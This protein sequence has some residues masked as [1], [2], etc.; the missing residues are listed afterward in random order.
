MQPSITFWRAW[1]LVVGTMVGSGVFLLPSVLGRFGWHG[2]WGWG[3]TATGAVVVALTIAWL[4]RRSPG[5]GG[6]YAYTKQAFGKLPAFFIAWGYWMSLWIGNAAI[7]VAFSGYAANLHPLL[8]NNEFYIAFGVV[9]VFTVVNWLGIA[10][11]G[12]VGLLFTVAKVVPLVL[13]GV[14][15]I[16]LGS[17]DTVA[18]VDITREGGSWIAA[19]A[20]MAMLALWAFTGLEAVTIPS[21]DVENPKQTL[22]KALITGVA[23]AAALY[24]VATFGVMMVVSTEQLATSGAPFA[25]AAQAL[26]GDVGGLLVGIGALIAIAGTLNALVMMSGQMAMAAA[27]DN[28]FPRIFAVKSKRGVPAA[29]IAIATVLSYAC[30]YLNFADTQSFQVAAIFEQL[31]LLSTLLILAPYLACTGAALKFAL[32]EKKY[33]TMWVIIPS[34]IFV[35]FATFGNEF[36]VLVKGAGLMLLGLPVYVLSSRTRGQRVVESI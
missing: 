10:T 29:G 24:I 23:S 35:A 18:P 14:M 16:I 34:A 30:I 4:S 2:L 11:A 20:S 36:D 3:V 28:V 21:E 26:F 32:I 12:F 22:P 31:I 25:D 6:P 1:A 13:I 27:E 33:S 17:T 15:G 9:T 19:V 5:L 8:A 7:A